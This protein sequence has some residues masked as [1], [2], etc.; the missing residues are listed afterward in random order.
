MVACAYLPV[1][2]ACAGCYPSHS[3]T[4]AI[5]EAGD[6]SA[7]QIFACVSGRE[8]LCMR[9]LSSPADSLCMCSPTMAG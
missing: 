2:L 8:I 3:H 1:H 4:G 5:G 7:H 6:V 9:L